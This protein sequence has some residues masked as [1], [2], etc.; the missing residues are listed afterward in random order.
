MFLSQFQ[1]WHEILTFHSS[2]HILAWCTIWTLTLTSWASSEKQDEKIWLVSAYIRDGWARRNDWNCQYL[3]CIVRIA[4]AHGLIPEACRKSLSTLWWFHSSYVLPWL[5]ARHDEFTT[6]KP[7]FLQF[8][9]HFWSSRKICRSSAYQLLE[10]AQSTGGH[11]VNLQP[12]TFIGDHLSEGV[13]RQLMWYPLAN[14]FYC[15]FS[16]LQQFSTQ[17]CSHILLQ[18]PEVKYCSNG[19]VL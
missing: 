17:L 15:F 8:A 12:R 9:I 6:W 7:F 4:M 3:P 10:W 13:L 19:D 2:E 18:C 1:P 14:V 16:N 11:S 5:K